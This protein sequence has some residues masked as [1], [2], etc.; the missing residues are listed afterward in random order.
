MDQNREKTRIWFLNQNSYMPDD[1]PHTRHYTL[2]KYLARIGYEPSVFA[3]NE[4]HHIGRRIDTGDARYIEKDEEGVRFFYIKTTHYEKNDY[5]RILNI[6]SYYRN[7]FKVCKEAAAKYGK[8]DVIYASSMYPTALVAGIKLAKKYGVKCICEHRDIIPDGFITKGT[9]KEN[10]LVARCMRLFM[11]RTY[12]QADALVFTMSGGPQH[13]MDLGLDTTHGGAIDPARVYY[14]NNGVD[15]EEFEKNAREYVLPDKDL[16]NESQFNVVYLG[17]IRFMNKMPLFIETARELKRLGRD[18]IKI[19]MW[20]T[21]TKVEEMKKQLQDEGLDNLELKGLVGKKYIPGIASRADLAIMTNNLSSVGK[22]GASP[23]KLFDYFAAGLPVIVPALLS[24]AMV[25][26]NGA[27]VELDEPDAS[28]LAEEIIS[29]ADM[30]KKEYEAY[31]VNSRSLA[32]QYSYE[33]LTEL[34]AEVIEAT[35]KG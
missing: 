18:D 7:I 11:K 4:L 5:R 30:D 25:Q 1:G 19:L 8:P 13:I 6:L 14:I 12:L 16:D 3:G 21:G 28:A 17:A 22:Y 31:R 15:M 9:F 2:G 24:D 27:G 32:D 29:F 26:K 34:V 23:N 10:G 20:G 35:M 33:H